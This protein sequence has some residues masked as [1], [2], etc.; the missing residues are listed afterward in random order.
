MPSPRADPAKVVLLA[1]PGASTNIIYHALV[2]TFGEVGEVVVVQEDPVPRSKFLRK[3][4]KRLG[5]PTV[6]G[7]LLFVLGVVPVLTLLGR[8]RVRD[9]SAGAGLDA[10]PIDEGRLVRVA[11]VNTEECQHL[12][13]RLDP[14]VV[15]VNGTRIIGQAT[16]DSVP[17]PF[18][19]MHAGITPR[20]RGVHGGYW[21]LAE[22]R[23]ALVGTTVHVV[24]KG[25]DTGPVLGQATFKP[26]P[27]D[28]FVTY[29]YLHLAAGLPLLLAAV[30]DVLEDR[31]LCGVESI[32]AA[33][34]SRLY[35]HPTLW[36]YL[37]ARL[38]KSVA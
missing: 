10:S 4:L 9:I 16:L 20:Y 17:A 7:Q 30:T 25:I 11:S 24:D 29:P 35:S 32:A 38:R 26:G 13:R 23:P 33:E 22:G 2:A 36:G 14:T 5:Y 21:A 27:S 31:A 12:L 18:V 19:N 1:G 34:G 28:S 15:V 37:C 8:A 3:R 6:I